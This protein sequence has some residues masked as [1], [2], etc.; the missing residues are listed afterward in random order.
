MKLLVIDDDEYTL[1]HI[2]TVAGGLGLSV[3]QATNAEYGI[4]ILEKLDEAVI[5][6]VDLMIPGNDGFVFCELTRNISLPHNPYIIAYS[7]LEEKDVLVRVLNSGADDFVQKGQDKSILLA[8]IDV[9]RRNIGYRMQLASD[10]DVLQVRVKQLE[11]EFDETAQL[12]RLHILSLKHSMD[13][14]LEQHLQAQTE[15]A[16]ATREWAN[17]L[18]S[19]TDGQPCSSTFDSVDLYRHIKMFM[20]LL[21]NKDMIRVYDGVSS[22]EASSYKANFALLKSLTKTLIM[23]IVSNANV[24]KVSVHIMPTSVQDN[25]YI[26]LNLVGHLVDE[27]AG[28]LSDTQRS[29]TK[30]IMDLLELLDGFLGFH[31]DNKMVKYR[32][33]FPISIPHSELA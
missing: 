4:G 6:I 13:L 21:P 3:Y 23:H 32:M 19:L 10:V 27:S 28:T 17:E 7:A 29:A 12:L 16:P 14:V 1:Q 24:E 11:K 25:N 33:C 2:A 20:S 15:L 26:E 22:V 30:N 31:M 18:L 8:R 5:V 9:A